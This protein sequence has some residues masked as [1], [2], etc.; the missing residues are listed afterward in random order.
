MRKGK[1][2]SWEKKTKDWN[3]QKKKLESNGIIIAMNEKSSKIH[4]S[5]EKNKD[6]N[7]NE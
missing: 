7:S 5:K 3:I 2:A 1:D 4:E 6:E